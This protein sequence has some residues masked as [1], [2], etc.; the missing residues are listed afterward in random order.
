MFWAQFFCMVLPIQVFHWRLEW[1]DRGFCT[2][3]C[4]ICSTSSITCLLALS[5]CC[6]LVTLESLE[7]LTLER[8]W[9]E[10]F[11]GNYIYTEI[12]NFVKICVCVCVASKE[13]LQIH[14]LGMENTFTVF[15]L[16]Y[17]LVCSNLS[18]LQTLLWM[19]LLCGQQSVSVTLWTRL[20]YMALCLWVLHHE[21]TFFSSSFEKI[22]PK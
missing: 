13:S 12:G 16:I 6:F 8:D 5:A 15:Q 20:S 2:V 7:E 18:K 3:N 9:K 14:L 21:P 1:S 22:R 19:L 4:S 11:W 17:G 10:M